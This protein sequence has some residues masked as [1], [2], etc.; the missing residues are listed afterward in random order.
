MGCKGPKFTWCNKRE[1]GL[2]CKKLDRFLVNEV[3][4]HKRDTSYGVF[5]ASGCSDHLRGRFHLQADA[6]GKRTPFKFTNAVTDSLDFLKM[7][8]D[9]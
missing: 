2:I 1:E 9:Y 5:E 6:M 3:R 7:I 4:L 8:E